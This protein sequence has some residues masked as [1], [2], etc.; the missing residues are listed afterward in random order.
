M[1]HDIYAAVFALNLLLIVFLLG[2]V[3]AGT[4]L[5]WRSRGLVRG[6]VVAVGAGFSYL[7]LFALA[8]LFISSWRV[9]DVTIFFFPVGWIAVAWGIL[10]MIR[11]GVRTS[12]GPGA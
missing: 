8:S 5:Y 6:R 2:I 11:H 9:N 4:I 3:S 12:E 10:G 1:Y 7:L